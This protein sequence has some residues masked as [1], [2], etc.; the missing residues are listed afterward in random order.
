MHSLLMAEI[1]FYIDTQR[2]FASQLG[3]LPRTPLSGGSLAPE[4][5][6]RAASWRASREGKARGKGRSSAG[7]EAAPVKLGRLLGG[8]YFSLACLNLLRDF[9]VAVKYLR[10]YIY[11]FE[12]NTIGV[13]ELALAWDIAA[14]YHRT[15]ARPYQG[16]QGSEGCLVQLKLSL[17]IANL[18]RH[19]VII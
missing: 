17:N 2:V 14:G 5:A 6:A 18:E 4:S 16:R 15:A 13:T 1:R 12:K 19:K 9:T 3:R 8:V 11:I 7:C 10:T